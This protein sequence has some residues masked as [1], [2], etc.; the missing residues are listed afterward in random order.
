MLNVNRNFI[1]ESELGKRKIA[2]FASHK[3]FIFLGYF[4]KNS[5]ITDQLQLHNLSQGMYFVKVETSSGI[6]TQ[7]LIKE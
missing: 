4:T 7:K 5:S 3:M 1:C 6:R 2:I